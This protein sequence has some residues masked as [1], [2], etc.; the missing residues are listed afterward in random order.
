SRSRIAATP[1]RS[2]ADGA[3]SRRPRSTSSSGRWAGAVPADRAGRTS[4]PRLPSSAVGVVVCE[5][6]SPRIDVDV[7]DD[8]AGMHA[9]IL[10]RVPNGPRSDG[11]VLVYLSNGTGLVVNCGELVRRPPGSPDLAS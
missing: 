7:A 5:N 6:P 8:A 2:T 9:Y 1:S 11:S 3:R 10:V 4:S